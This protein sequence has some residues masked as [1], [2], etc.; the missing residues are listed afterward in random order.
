MTHFTRRLTNT[1]K[2][3]AYRMLGNLDNKLLESTQ[4]GNPEVVELLLTAGANPNS[5]DSGG[6]SP[7]HLAARNGFPTV[8][9][10]LLKAGADVNKAGENGWTPLHLAAKQGRSLV[11]PTLLDA[12]ADV[13]AITPQSD[14]DSAF[15]AAD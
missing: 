1:L 7:L 6:E 10:S 11:V 15:L 12:G 4:K 14:H 5:I 9:S 3:C 8:A 13:D 2:V